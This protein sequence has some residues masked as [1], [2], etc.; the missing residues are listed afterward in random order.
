MELNT[1]YVQIALLLWET[2]WGGGQIAVPRVERG[3]A[4]I[5]QE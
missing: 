1:K 2:K 5:H 4:M 3:K